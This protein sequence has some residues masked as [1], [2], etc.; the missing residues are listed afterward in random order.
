MSD[1]N[2]TRF[3]AANYANLQGLHAVP[4]GLLL[5]IVVLWANTQ[6]G[7]AANLTLPLLAAAILLALAVGI[8]RYYNTRFGKVKSTPRQKRLELLL[9]LG[10]GLVGL[11]AFLADIRLRLPFSC[12]GLVFA[13]A[14]VV[15]YWRMQQAA[16]G[17]YLLPNTVVYTVL[18]S[19]ASLLPLFGLAGWWEWF[20]LRGQLYGILTVAALI[21]LVAGL[22]GHWYFVRQLPAEEA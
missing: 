7:R 16:P 14:F 13:A 20:G 5:L 6:T 15:E 11:G 12:I 2:K 21:I 18:M 22:W 1:L 3:L 10:G 8:Q 4:L 17:R 9:S 19:I